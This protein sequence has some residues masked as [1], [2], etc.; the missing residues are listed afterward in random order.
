MSLIAVILYFLKT[1]IY[2]WEYRVIIAL[3]L[4]ILP[5]RR[6]ISRRSILNRQIPYTNRH[7]SACLRT[8]TVYC[9][10]DIVDLEKKYRL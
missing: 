1:H 7:Q 4:T 2:L 6:K 8:N 5:A 9:R 3:F 10:A